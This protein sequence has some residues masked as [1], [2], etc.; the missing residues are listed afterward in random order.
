MQKFVKILER[1]VEWIA[2]GLGGLFLLF[3]VWTYGIGHPASVKIGTKELHADDIDEQIYNDKGKMLSTQMAGTEKIELPSKDILSPYLARLDEKDAPTPQFVIFFGGS[4]G[5]NIITG[6]G[7]D[8][9]PAQQKIAQLPKL[10]PA[11]FVNESHGITTID[12][13]ADPNAKG[14]A[15]NVQQVA[16]PKDTTYDSLRF[17]VKMEDVKKAFDEAF[18][19]D[20]GVDKSF[21]YVS[22]FLQVELIRQEK[23][24]N[25]QWSEPTTLPTQN[26]IGQPYPGDDPPPNTR[27]AVA[28]Y[29]N[30]AGNAQKQ[31]LT[32]A[33]PKVV[34]GAPA[35]TAPGQAAAGGAGKQAAPPPA[36]RP[37]PPAVM[38][39]NPNPGANNGVAAQL[40]QGEFNVETTKEDK[41]IVVHD[42]TAQDGKTYRYAIKY[43]LSNPVYDVNN[44][45]APALAQKFA[46]VS[47]PSAW[48]KEIT[49]EPHTRLFVT[50][51]NGGNGRVTFELW[52]YKLGK[53]ENK[54]ID[55]AAGDS[56]KDWTVVDV[57]KEP[58]KES[59]SY[60]LLL[61]GNGELKKHTKREDLMDL[62]NFK[63]QVGPKQAAL[64]K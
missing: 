44:I 9:N 4:R 59:N 28:E 29:K 58:T 62:D 64:A 6:P 36:A 3:M 63:Q 55:G 16:N 56:I 26:G 7:N 12:P 17:T 54:R 43:K 49:I 20:I 41:E 48:S 53:Y 15:G 23:L 57:R 1:N 51:V 10:P 38:P 37:A 8:N 39:F 32:P 21:L 42:L 47:E 2:L 14:A 24:P 45:A 40:N 5:D 19:K 60:A 22:R 50:N 25:G 46:L 52:E 11:T 61:D 18:S 34:E 27:Q 31:I 13:N 33:F 30:A 35:W